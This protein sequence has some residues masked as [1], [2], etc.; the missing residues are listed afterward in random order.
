MASLEETISNLEAEYKEFQE[1]YENWEHNEAIHHL[2]TSEKASGAQK[3]MRVVLRNRCELTK[4][5][6]EMLREISPPSDVQN[7]FVDKALK[8]FTD[9][10]ENS[11]DVI[12]ATLTEFTLEDLL[13]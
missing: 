5:H 12:T 4:K 2:S 9:I 1:R 3:S 11:Q 6:L 8:D 10:W 13:E 7:E